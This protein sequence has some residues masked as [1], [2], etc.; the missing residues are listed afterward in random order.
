MKL[1]GS[2]FELLLF[3]RGQ[4][5]SSTVACMYAYFVV[6]TFA[7]AMYYSTVVVCSFALA[8]IITIHNSRTS[9]VLV[10]NAGCAHN[11][12]HNHPVCI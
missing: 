5:S 12:Q 3:V 10:S 6:Y 8:L 4:C 11:T 1:V 7:L 2:C 9:S